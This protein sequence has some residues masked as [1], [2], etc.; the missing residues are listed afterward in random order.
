[1]EQRIKS[2][3]VIKYRNEHYGFPVITN[4][5][6]T[7]IFNELIN[8]TQSEKGTFKIDYSDNSNNQECGVMLKT[9]SNY[10]SLIYLTVWLI[11]Y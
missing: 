4:Q 8:V 9:W 1:M 5:E 6:K 10:K 2:K 7:L 3:K 11:D